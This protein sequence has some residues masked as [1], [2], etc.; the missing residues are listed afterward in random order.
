MSPRLAGS[1]LALCV[2]GALGLGCSLFRSSSG[3]TVVTDVGGIAACV[4]TH[5]ETDPDP[6]FEG[7]AVE[8]AGAAVADVV[9]IVTALASTS[10]T[11]ADAGTSAAMPRAALVRHRAA[12]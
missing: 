11:T 1:L 9:S 4:I 6:T 12:R 8:C 10:K 5:V 2:V 3:Q 7:I